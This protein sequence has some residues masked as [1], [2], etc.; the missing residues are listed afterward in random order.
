MGEDRGKVEFDAVIFRCKQQRREMGDTC[1]R[2]SSRSG[3]WLINLEY[4][5][6]FFIVFG[7]VFG[8]IHAPEMVLF[9]GGQTVICKLSEELRENR[10]W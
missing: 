7:H 2:G 8:V 9:F 10:E 1:G 6:A 3:I 4:N 5:T